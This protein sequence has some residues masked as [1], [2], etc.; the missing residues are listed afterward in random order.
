MVAALDLGWHERTFRDPKSRTERRYWENRGWFGWQILI[1]ETGVL[2]KEFAL[3][4]YGP[5]SGLRL[6][7]EKLRGKPYRIDEVIDPRE[8]L[9]HP[10]LVSVIH[11]TS[12]KGA[13]YAKIDTIAPV[14]AGMTVPAATLGQLV[15]DFAEGKPWP[16]VSWLQSHL[17]GEPIA[18]ILAQ[19]KKEK[20]VASPSANGAAPASAPST[21][22]TAPANA[23]AA[24]AS[25]AS[26]EPSF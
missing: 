9:G 15:W 13:A 19:A 24:P 5:K 20:L 4:E 10:C 23:P 6:L 26:Q 8:M 11:Q 14:L 7:M 1:A 18:D 25:P 21:N 12:K 16:A 3:A 22:G 2:F 17:Y